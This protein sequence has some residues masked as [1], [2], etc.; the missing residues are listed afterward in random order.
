MKQTVLRRGQGLISAPLFPQPVEGQVPVFSSA[1][2]APSWRLEPSEPDHSVHGTSLYEPVSASFP[3][4]KNAPGAPESWHSSKLQPCIVLSTPAIPQAKEKITHWADWLNELV[5]LDTVWPHHC[6][7]LPWAE[8]RSVT[9]H[10]DA[11]ERALVVWR[12]RV[13]VASHTEAS[14]TR[15]PS[16]LA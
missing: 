2:H 13:R 16:T 4:G 12:V 14:P 15:I 1:R 3:D 9:F 7:L 11:I 6:S 5:G 10:H 8:H